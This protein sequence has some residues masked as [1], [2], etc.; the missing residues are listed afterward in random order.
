MKISYQSANGPMEVEL[1]ASG[2]TVTYAQGRIEVPYANLTAM[3]LADQLYLQAGPQS[4]M[5]IPLSAFSSQE[6]LNS[7]GRIILEH[8][9]ALAVSVNPSASGQ[10]AQGQPPAQGPGQ[11]AA[12]N[13]DEDDDDE[14]N[15]Q[16]AEELRAFMEK[17]MRPDGRPGCL[18]LF[19]ALI[20]FVKTITI[21]RFRALKPPTEEETEDFFA[22]AVKVDDARSLYEAAVAR[23]AEGRLW[24]YTEVEGL[25]GDR[26]CLVSLDFAE[27]QD[28]PMTREQVAAYDY[29]KQNFPRL[30]EAIIQAL[31][32]ENRQMREMAKTD[33]RAQGG[34]LAIKA[35]RGLLMPP[36]IKSPEKFEKMLQVPRWE[37]RREHKDG[38]AYVAVC[39]TPHWT[40]NTEGVL[41]HGDQIVFVGTDP[42]FFDLPEGGPARPPQPNQA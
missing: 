34:G 31:M 3:S 7:F 1:T 17:H 37:L 38:L 41:L 15:E 23:L 21:G 8:N 30:K 32:E 2:L 40:V 35:A 28:Q 27:H 9:P 42:D 4:V 24:A 33:S 6:Q 20:S 16:D 12:S 18:L 5:G 10:T 13:D 36:D 25:A 22:E 26:R 11:A 39:Y 19:L 14:D 29:M